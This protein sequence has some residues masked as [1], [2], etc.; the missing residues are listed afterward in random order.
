MAGKSKIT[1][2][3]P[4]VK[5]VI[6]RLLAQ[7]RHTLDEII[8]HLRDMDV[9]DVSRSSLHRYAQTF[10]SV[11]AKI[12]QSREMAR[13]FAA[14]IGA[15]EDTDQHETITQMMHTLLM[16]AGMDAIDQEQS[17]DMKGLSHMAKALKDLM[18]SVAQREKLKAEAAQEA[19]EQAAEKADKVMKTAGVTGATALAIRRAVLGVDDSE[20]EPALA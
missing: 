3:D 11:N 8:E 4:R 16:R 5:T 6:D 18:T 13:A 15:S 20:A 17:P 14:E 10:E 12:R 2:I 19:R 1:R 9:E 7:N